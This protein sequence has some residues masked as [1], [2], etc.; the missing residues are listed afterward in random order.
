MPRLHLYRRAARALNDFFSTWTAP[1]CARCLEVTAWANPDDPRAAVEWADGRFP[2]CCHAGVGDTKTIP[3]CRGALPA[4]LAA[5]L[6][7]GR[8]SRAQGQADEGFYRLRERNSGRLRE[9]RGCRYLGPQGCRAGECKAPLCLTYLCDGVRAAL[10]EAAGP[11]WCGVGEDDFCGASRVL[12]AVAT[13]PLPQAE[14]EVAAL[15][16]RLLRLSRRLQ[17]VG[18]SSGTDLV[19]RWLGSFTAVRVS[20][21]QSMYVHDRPCCSSHR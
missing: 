16:T 15:E 5:A 21:C 4:G 10:E 17:A 12:G 20:P 9:G 14:R 11:G 8:Q 18:A 2:G 1:F 6:A 3:S 19:E 7:A 13:A